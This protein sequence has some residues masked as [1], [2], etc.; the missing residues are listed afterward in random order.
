MK[1]L[2][3]ALYRVRKTC[4]HCSVDSLLSYGQEFLNPVQTFVGAVDSLLGMTAVV[5]QMAE[6]FAVAAV[7]TFG[8]QKRKVLHCHGNF[9][10]FSKVP[11]DLV[12]AVDYP[13]VAV[14][15]MEQL[16]AVIEVLDRELEA[17]V[18]L[19][20]RVP[21]TLK[22]QGTNYSVDFALVAAIVF[23]TFS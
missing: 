16:I 1:I 6:L 15:L 22:G 23:G 14:V 7:L 21:A 3:A 12:V 9:L 2:A 20:V 10:D 4:S 19:Q 8:I 13:A 11:A 18:P 5:V 17:V